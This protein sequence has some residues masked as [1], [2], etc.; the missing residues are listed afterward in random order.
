MI[1]M[2]LVVAVSR[3]IDDYDSVDAAIKQYLDSIRDLEI[4]HGGAD[5]VDTL[6]AQ[7]ADVYALETTVFEPNWDEYGKA[8]GPI[9]NEEMAKY[10][11]ALV[12]VWDGGSNGTRSMIEKALDEGIEVYV[13][14]VNDDQ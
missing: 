5:G 14:V 3:S 10:G 11:D 1:D 2:K 4:V 13:K 12:A 6:A 7:F 8:A 9:R